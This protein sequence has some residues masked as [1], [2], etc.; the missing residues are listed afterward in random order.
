MSNRTEFHGKDLVGVNLTEDSRQ[1]HTVSNKPCLVIASILASFVLL[2]NFA[3]AAGYGN[4]NQGCAVSEP[5]FQ[6][7]YQAGNK[8][9]F[10]F[11]GVTGWDHYNV[12]YAK[13]GGEKQVENRSGS[14]TFNNVQPNRVYTIKVQGCNT[15]TFGGSDCT[16][17]VEQS[18][19]TR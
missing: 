17:W 8:I 14:Y 2:P 16:N 7:A 15:H 12:R 10:K 1:R 5:C 4:D 11:N 6:E 13:G 3:H 18:V 9:I 19:T